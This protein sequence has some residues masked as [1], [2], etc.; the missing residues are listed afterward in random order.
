MSSVLVVEDDPQIA[1]TIELRLSVEAHSV[2][3]VHDVA[4]AL[5]TLHHTTPDVV[6]LDLAVP[7]GGG[8]AVAEHLSQ[9]L[10]EVAIVF[11]TAASH[12]GLERQADRFHPR[13]YLQ[14]PFQG[15]E[16][17]AAIRPSVLESTAARVH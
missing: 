9:A 1:R 10:P 16:L 12:P 7:G 14:K 6:V 3:V 5:L 11:L 4:S 13:A 8:F 2:L 15:S 17:L